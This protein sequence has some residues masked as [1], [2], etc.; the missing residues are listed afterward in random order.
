MAKIFLSVVGIAYVV[1]AVWCAAL[2]G[3]T[4]QAVGFELKP[5]SG[6][7]E[8]FVIYGGLQ[9]ALGAA[10]LWPHFRADA[11]VWSLG[12]CTIIHVCIVVFRT[13]GFFRFSGIGTTTYALAVVE[14]IILIGAAWLWY[15]ESSAAA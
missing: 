5:G 15:R 13:I 14:W 7:S 4:S 3:K 6:E 2:P 8:Y 10:F 12:L 1:L 11:L 9:L